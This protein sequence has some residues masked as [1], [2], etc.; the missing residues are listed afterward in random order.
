MKSSVFALGFF[1]IFIIPRQIIGKPVSRNEPVIVLT[2]DTSTVLEEKTPDD[3]KNMET[4]LSEQVIPT[5]ELSISSTR[6]TLSSISTTRIKKKRTCV[7]MD[8]KRYYLEGEQGQ[9][10]KVEMSNGVS[11]NILVL[12]NIKEASKYVF[13]FVQFSNCDLII[14][15]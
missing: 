7:K 2:A 12:E 14:V 5:R 1:L 3:L 11:A 4:N 10:H 8:E 13:Y 6:T 9:K 15:V